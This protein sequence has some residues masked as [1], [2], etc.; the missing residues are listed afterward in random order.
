MVNKK[1]AK[2][3]TQLPQV[4]PVPLTIEEDLSQDQGD[5]P[6]P[7][8]GE[9]WPTLP[10]LGLIPTIDLSNLTTA[11]VTNLPD[12]QRKFSWFIKNLVH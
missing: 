7:I 3:Q 5:R 10:T 2:T 1:G 9:G 6:E 12:C 8:K 11:T 4:E